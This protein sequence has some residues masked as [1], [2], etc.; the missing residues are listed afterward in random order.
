[1]ILVFDIVERASFYGVN[2]RLISLVQVLSEISNFT[3][4]FCEFGQICE[5]IMS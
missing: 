3:F 1:M 2:V 4:G 5:A